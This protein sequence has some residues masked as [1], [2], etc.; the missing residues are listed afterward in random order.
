[1]RNPINPFEY[2]GVVAENAFCNRAREKADLAKAIRNHEKLF[3][4]SECRFGKTSLVQMVLAGFS[5]KSAVCAYVDLWLTDNEATFVTALAK[6]ITQS[7]SSSLPGSA[8]LPMRSAPSMAC[9]IAM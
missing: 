1:M 3:V 9:P 6:A 2:G 5:R 8:R 7:M 4:F